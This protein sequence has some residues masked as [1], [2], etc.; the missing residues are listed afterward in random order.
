[1]VNYDT[2]IETVIDTVYLQSPSNNDW[3]IMKNIV[4]TS[5]SSISSQIST[6][7]TLIAGFSLIFVIS[8]IFLSFYISFLVRKVKLAKK[9]I[10]EKEKKIDSLAKTVEETDAKIQSD[11]SGLYAKLRNEESMT[12]L[13]RLEEEPL[14][15]VN[16]EELLLARPLEKEGFPILKRAYIKLCELGQDIDVSEFL[17]P[18]PRKQFHLLFFQHYLGETILDNN[19]RPEML[20]DFEFG[21]SCAFT[22]DIIK[23]TED[24]CSALS[25]N[26]A[27]FDKCDILV[28]YLKALNNSK[29]KDL[30]ELKNIFENN[31][32]NHNL[33]PNA[34]E[35]CM[36]DKVYLALFG[37]TPSTEEQNQ[38]E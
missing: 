1:M 33:L 27:T 34:I 37:I 2:I 18:S 11:I 16:I 20:K 23:S 15:I 21:M 19:L 35:K 25:D 10:E 24:F 9:S 29:Y 3:D 22:R 5:N 12:L 38:Q 31:I 4:E 6:L 14:D 13:H 30:V 17:R 26:T 36:Q 8:S 28:N 32:S 7:N